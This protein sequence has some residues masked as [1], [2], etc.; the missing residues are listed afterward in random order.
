MKEIINCYSYEDRLNTLIN[1]L[2]QGENIYLFGNGNN[3]KSYLI[4]KLS[5]V[6]KAN[7]YN[8]MTE[9]SQP[10]FPSFT[11]FI[12]SSENNK[13]IVMSNFPPNNDVINSNFVQIRFVGK[14][15]KKT[16]T[17]I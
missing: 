10:G 16:M 17:Y 13:K 2:N 4:N 3:G 8:I 12:G 6:V 11:A 15:D 14:F 5:D 7:K 9:P 1:L